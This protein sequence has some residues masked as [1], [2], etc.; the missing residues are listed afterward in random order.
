MSTA[1]QDFDYSIRTAG[2][3][4]FLTDEVR[5]VLR[6]QMEYAFKRGDLSTGE[7]NQ[8]ADTLGA[9]FNKKYNRVFEIASLGEPYIAVAA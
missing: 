8:L 9:D 4:G 5:L 6:A 7:I 2:D 3:K 1:F